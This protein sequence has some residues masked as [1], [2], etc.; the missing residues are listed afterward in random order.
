MSMSLIFTYFGDCIFALF[1]TGD[2][3]FHLVVP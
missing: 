2:T 1:T 3:R